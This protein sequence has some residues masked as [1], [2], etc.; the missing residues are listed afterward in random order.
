MQIV[1]VGHKEIKADNIAQTGHVWKRGEVHEV[2]DE[3]KALKLLEHS[4]IWADATNKNLKE[5]EKLL[6]PEM[7]AVPPEPRVSFM[8]K[9]PDS[10]FWEPFLVVVP[11]D[12]YKKLQSKKLIP[13][14]MSPE[15]AD[16]LE[17]SRNEPPNDAMPEETAPR[18][19]GPK[20][21]ARETRQ[22]LDTKKV[23]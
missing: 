10:P 18:R 9:D 8:P 20:P 1:Y 23:A 3:K 16:A 21:Q 4:L 17:A 13:V 12:V 19:T 14:F 6:L 7:K 2:A 11:P 22:G 15:A 5:I